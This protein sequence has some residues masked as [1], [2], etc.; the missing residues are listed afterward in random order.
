MR[1]ALAMPTRIAR[2][3]EPLGLELA[4][5]DLVQLEDRMLHISGDGGGLDVAINIAPSLSW[6][7]VF[8]GRARSIGH[9]IARPRPVVPK[10]RVAAGVSGPRAARD[11]SASQPD[12]PWPRL[13]EVQLHVVWQRRL[14]RRTNA[15]NAE[16]RVRLVWRRRIDRA[17]GPRGGALS[18]ADIDRVRPCDAEP[19]S[20]RRA[21]RTASPAVLARSC[22]QGNG[23]DARRSAIRTGWPSC[24]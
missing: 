7:T 17:R 22:Q 10:P 24:A 6:L 8:G 15:A 18:L 21:A 11:D 20:V 16:A 14:G 4:L 23:P 1:G 3:G 9:G 19:R 13:R 12:V 5:T 2:V